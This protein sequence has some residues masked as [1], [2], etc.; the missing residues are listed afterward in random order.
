MGYFP[1]FMDIG[2][3]KGVIVGGGKVAAGKVG[4]LAAFGP[5]LTVIAPRIE[6]CMRAQEKLFQEDVA[7]TLLFC[8]R[9]FTTEDLDGA[10]FVIAATDDASLN[11]R[12]SACCMERHIPVNVVDDREKCSF[13]F[14]ALVREGNLTVGVSTDGKSPLAAA[15]V[16]EEISRILPDKIGD[17]VNL[18]GQVRPYVKELKAEESV[19]KEILGKLFLYCL[20]K[21]G[22]VTIG[23]LMDRFMETA[24]ESI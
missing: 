14:P 5:H 13:F 15:W 4:K 10:D 12:V 2:G 17:I 16:K 7:A 22:E 18:M 1:F 8:Q 23:E 19:R 21:D 24:E 11:G 20:E 6:A 3:K 9:E